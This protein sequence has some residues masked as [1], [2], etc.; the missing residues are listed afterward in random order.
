MNYAFMAYHPETIGSWSDLDYLFFQVLAQEPE[1][2]EERIKSAFT[3]IPYL[4]SSLFMKRVDLI[5]REDE[6]DAYGIILDEISTLDN[7]PLALYKG[8]HGSV[9]AYEGVKEMPLLEYLLKFLSAYSFTTD[10]KSKVQGIESR[11]INASV[12]G[13]VFEKLNGYKDGS[14]YTPSFITTYICKESM[15]EALVGRVNA[16]MQENFADYSA[17]K[18]L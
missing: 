13:N 6:E 9:L 16:E 3:H 5:Y 18:S 2:R 1:H 15:Q 4:N 14:F 11:L 8:D 12:L 10:G 7:E 17:L